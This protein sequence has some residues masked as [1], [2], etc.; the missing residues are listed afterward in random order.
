MLGSLST[1][2]HS[3]ISQHHYQSAQSDLAP[4]TRP[5]PATST[6]SQEPNVPLTVR[7]TMLNLR[8][9]QTLQTK[10]RAQAQELQSFY[11]LRSAEVESARL[12]A[13]RSGT[14]NVHVTKSIDAY[15]DQNHNSLIEQVEVSLASL[16]AR[17][18]QASQLRQPPAPASQ[19]SSNKS[20]IGSVAVRIMTSWYDRNSEHPYPSYETCGVMAKAGNI[21]IDQVKKWFANRRLRLSHT[22][23]IQVIAKRRKRSRTVSQDDIL[24]SGGSPSD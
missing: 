20:G 18:A 6:S 12:T 9:M 13:L 14:S 23:S 3:S 15:Y 8:F 5:S 11:C 22:K 10:T 7:I 17:H 19:T 1:W 21:T 2:Q 4:P 24:F 16:E